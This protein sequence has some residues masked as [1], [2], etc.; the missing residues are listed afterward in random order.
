MAQLISKC[1]TLTELYLANNEIDNDGAK[2][3]VK[4]I[5]GRKDFRNI[6]LDN[7][8][9]SGEAI[10]ELFTILPLNKL[11]LIKSVLAEAQVEPLAK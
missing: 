8:H 9:F 7:N 3:L 4:A 6:D 11:N 2:L 10:T 1:D 5:K